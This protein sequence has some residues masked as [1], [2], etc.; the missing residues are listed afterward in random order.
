MNKL[1][2]TQWLLIKACIE[3]GQGKNQGGK[4]Y[5][6]NVTFDNNSHLLVFFLHEP[7]LA[8]SLHEP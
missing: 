3:D 1:S 8:S 2:L 4:I 7:T 6:S 5:V